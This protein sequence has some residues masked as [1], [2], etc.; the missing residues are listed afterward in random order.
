MARRAAHLALF[1][2]KLKPREDEA[3]PILMVRAA[4]CEPEPKGD[5]TLHAIEESSREARHPRCI[6]LK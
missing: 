4:Q 6:E 3:R 1:E 5:G 2:P